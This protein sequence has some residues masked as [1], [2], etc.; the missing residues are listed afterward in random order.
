VIVG[1]VSL[2]PQINVIRG[3]A[4][5][6]VRA[7]MSGTMEMTI[8][9]KLVEEGARHTVQVSLPLLDKLIRIWERALFGHGK[10][11]T[12]EP[13]KLRS[14]ASGRGSCYVVLI[15]LT[16]TVEKNQAQQHRQSSRQVT[17]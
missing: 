8:A 17:A 14:V 12:P 16:C 5:D 1:R 13:S 10:W 9:W 6:H 7:C 4:N 11:P 3:I 2:F 15:K